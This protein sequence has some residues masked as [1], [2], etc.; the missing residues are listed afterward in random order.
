MSIKTSKT[1][2]QREKTFGRGEGTKYPRTLGQFQK[3]TSMHMMSARKRRER[4]RKRERHT[5]PG[6]EG[7]GNAGSSNGRE[8]SPS[9]GQTPSH[10]SRKPRKPSWVK[11]AAEDKKKSTAR[12]FIYILQKIK[13]KE[14]SLE[15]S[16]M[17][18]AP[19]LWR[20][21]PNNLWLRLCKQRA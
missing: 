19:Y 17:R 3:I 16:W 10:Q 1:E 6:E 14:K 2:R 12:H 18:K 11:I 21:K 4:K 20:N 5:R 13:D 9:S 8:F 7:P 15:R